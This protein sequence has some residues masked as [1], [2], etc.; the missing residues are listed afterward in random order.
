MRI[1]KSSK[2][3]GLVGKLKAYIVYNQV[4][5]GK[6]ILIAKKGG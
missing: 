5:E 6:S 3:D 2:R 1:M 4:Y